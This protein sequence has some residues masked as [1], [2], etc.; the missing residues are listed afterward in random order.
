MSFSYDLATTVGQM[1]IALADTGGVAPGATAVAGSYGFEDEEL[2]Y[3]YS[4]GGS[5][6]GGI[7]RAIRALLLDGA[8][9]ERAFSLPNQTYD[10]KGR[11]AAL[12]AAL[13]LYG[14]EMPTVSVRMPAPIASDSGYR[15][16]VPST[17]YS[18]GT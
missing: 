5:L 12:K 3:F 16:P 4:A 10:D 11:T 9:R 2:T 14:D 8:R 13:S 15:D 18:T 17:I 6:N 1:R 7:A